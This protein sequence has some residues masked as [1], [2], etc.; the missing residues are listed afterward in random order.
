MASKSLESLV[1]MVTKMSTITSLTLRLFKFVNIPMVFCLRKQWTVFIS[2]IQV[3]S[4][5]VVRANALM[6]WKVEPMIVLVKTCMLYL[7]MRKPNQSLGASGFQERSRPSSEFLNAKILLPLRALLVPI[8]IRFMLQ[9]ICMHQMRLDLSMARSL[10]LW[11]YLRKLPHLSS[12][13]TPRKLQWILIESKKKVSKS[14][15]LAR[16]TFSSF[17]CSP[18]VIKIK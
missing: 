3:T 4:L 13:L 17:S 7:K 12:G 10:I 9:I 8:R 16:L 6:P 5:K 15:S 14:L 18:V 1:E 11:D 2:K